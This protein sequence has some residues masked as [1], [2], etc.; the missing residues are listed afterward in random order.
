MK[1]SAQSDH[2]NV[3]GLWNVKLLYIIGHFLKLV[4]VIKKLILEGKKC[5]TFWLKVMEFL[6]S[7]IKFTFMH[8]ANINVHKLH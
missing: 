1:G 3:T 2:F 4:Y 7:V 5:I 6:K 8:L